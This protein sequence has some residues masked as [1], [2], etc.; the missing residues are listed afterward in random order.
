M[1]ICLLWR[2]LGLTGVQGASRSA[3]DPACCLTLW[4]LAYKGSARPAK[5][6]ADAPTSAMPLSDVQNLYCSLASAGTASVGVYTGWVQ[7]VEVVEVLCL[8]DYDA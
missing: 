1:E 6:V 5:L 8:Y 2:N 3:N 7:E 4:K